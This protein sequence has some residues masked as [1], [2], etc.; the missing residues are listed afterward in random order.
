MNWEKI[1]QACVLAA[2][3]ALR[4]VTSAKTLDDS[5]NPHTDADLVSHA[6]IMKALQDS[7]A[8]CQVYS[9]E[10]DGKIVLN[11]GG[12]SIVVVDPI[13]NTVFFMRGLLSSCAISMFIVEDGQPL[14]SFVGDIARGDVYHCDQ[15]HSYKNGKQIRVPKTTLGKMILAGWAPYTPRM[16]AFYEKF[17]RLPQKEFL[18]FNHG[19]ILENAQIAD[20]YFDAGFQIVPTKLQEF[21]GAIVAWRAGGEISTLEGNPIVWDINVKQT[22]LVSRSKE[23]HQKLL[24][25]FN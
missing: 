22:M 20:G 1:G 11:G 16:E 18:M 9:E 8:A 10:A 15:A 6:A 5:I 17:T 14:C 3:D 21:A 23:I 2:F 12:K 25:S 19:S 24:K 7:G 13:D 4:G